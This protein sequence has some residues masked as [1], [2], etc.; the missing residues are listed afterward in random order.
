MKRILTLVLVLCLALSALAS[1]AVVDKVKD[2]IGLGHEHSFVEGKCECGE[3][4]PDYVPEE[5]PAVDEG[6]QGAYD[7]IHQLYKAMGNTAGSYDLINTVDIAGVAYTV[8]WTVDVESITVTEKEDKSGYTVNV[9]A[10]ELGDAA[11]N[12]KLTFVVA[13]AAGDTL[14]RTYDLVVPEFKVSTLAEYY[15]AEAGT[16]LAVQGVVTG[17]MS[18][19]AGDKENSI[20]LQDASNEGGY[21]VYALADDPAGTI[22]VGMTVLVKG[23]KDIYNGTHEVK[24][25]S[26]EIVNSEL[27][28]VNPVDITE[29][30]S[31]AVNTSAAEL[32]GKQGLLV[33]IKGVT[34]LDAGSNGSYNWTLAGKNSYL[35]ISS[36]SNCTTA[37]QEATIKSGFAANY[38][39]LAD[40]TGLV[41]VYNNSF[42]L[43]PL[44]ENAFSNFVVTDKP[45]NI[46]VEVETKNLSINKNIVVPGNVTLPTAGANFT[47]VAISWALAETTNATL[48]GNVLT[49]VLPEE[50]EVK[51]TLTA[52]L[53]KGEESATKDIEVTIKALV[54]TSI[55]DANEIAAGQSD[56]TYTAEKYIVDGIIS[57]LASTTHGNPTIVDAEGNELYI[58]GIYTADGVTKYGDMTGDKP[59]VGDTVRLLGTLGQYNGKIQMQSGW[60]LSWSHN[61]EED[62]KAPT[63]TEAGSTTYT[64][65]CG[66]NY[67]EAGEAATGHTW[68]EDNKCTN[69]GCTAV[70]H[71]HDYTYNTVVTDPTCSAGGYTTHYCECGESI[72]DS[73]T[74]ASDHAD[75][76]GDY[77]CDGNCG[78]LILPEDGATLTIEQANA[79]GVLTTTTQKYYVTGYITGFY[80]SSGTTYGNVYVQDADGKSILVYGLYKDGV[81]YDAMTTKPVKGDTIKV[82]GVLTSYNGTAQFKDAE[83]IEHTVHECTE[84]TD[85]TCQKKA[86]CVIC[87]A[88]SGDLADH[89]YVDGKCSVCKHEEGSTAAILPGNLDFSGAANKASAD[90]YMSTNY[91]TWTIT[92]KLGQ[93]Y[94]GYLGFGRSGDGSSAIKSSPISVSNAFTITT[95]L[96]GNGSNGVVTSTLTF[97][98]VDA[99]GNLVATGYADGSTTAAITPVD[100]KDTTYNIAFTLEEGK[101][102][103]DVANLVITFAKSTGNIGLKTLTFVQ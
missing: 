102:W 70:N 25:A 47:D 26:V 2:M 63:C 101:A 93:T 31:N 71:T 96:K 4:D 8:T 20:F 67:T 61:Y 60:L 44:T 89:N 64:C 5:K 59:Q 69:D 13:N 29:I 90:S 30:F 16:A 68:G 11:I 34:V 85:A 79:I 23:D 51:I 50:G 100:A 80:G 91:P 52:T 15:E 72:K 27:T 41:T 76:N 7:Y 55:P 88:E 66:A 36:S 45:D 58:Y 86:T 18:K 42:Y 6:L 97:T 54:I 40:V 39:N 32:I 77:K 65:A 87:G 21:Y 28:T 53:T 1:C 83:L 38:Y 94:G 74:E 84:Y 95:V 99:N 22:Q 75:A 49:P 73:E 10:L 56:K 78:T 46:Q 17:I 57:N 12:Y 33:T 3:V 48:A 98:L 92:G 37:D 35:R 9:P 14:T 19:G 43:A 24:N 103:T 82:Y 62:V 81:R